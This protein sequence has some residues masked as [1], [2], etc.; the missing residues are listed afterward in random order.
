MEGFLHYLIILISLIICSCGPMQEEEVRKK[1]INIPFEL[2]DDFKARWPASIQSTPLNLLVHPSFTALFPKSEILNPVQQWNKKLP[3]LTFIS[4]TLASSGLNLNRGLDQFYDGEMGV[5]YMNSWYDD[6]SPDA[7][8]ITQYYG[9]PRFSSD[10]GQY[11]ELVHAD[12][13]INGRDHTY[14]NDPNDM[15]NYDI[16]SVLVHELGHFIGLGHVYDFSTDSVMFPFLGTDETIRVLGNDDFDLLNELYGG[17]KSLALRPKS[18]IPSL[19]GRVV[20]PTQL[21]RGIIQLKKDGHCEHY[22]DGLL[23][24]GH[25]VNLNRL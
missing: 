1:G 9:L 7:L 10:L 2:M 3:A 6:L 5:Y 16:Q 4:E 21:T 15:I 17:Y 8:A 18:G 12:I 23:I 14:S 24:H 19:S 13:I 11:I 22:R 20:D 25:K